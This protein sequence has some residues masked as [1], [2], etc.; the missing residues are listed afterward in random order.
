MGNISIAYIGKDKSYQENLKKALI[1]VIGSNFI[2]TIYDNNSF[3]PHL[4]FREISQSNIEVIYIDFNFNLNK[5]IKLAKYLR[6]DNKAKLLSTVSLH[7][8]LASTEEILQAEYSGIRLLHIKSGE[9]SDVVYDAL[10][11]LENY[12]FN[13]L[14]YKIAKL[15]DSAYFT[16]SL[17][18]AKINSSLFQVE[19]SSPLV[20]NEIIEIVNAPFKMFN[21][22][23]YFQ[24]TKIRDF[25]LYYDSRFSIDLVPLFAPWEIEEIY[26]EDSPVPSDLK[27]EPAGAFDIL[28]RNKKVLNRWISTQENKKHIIKKTKIIVYDSS[29]HILETTSKDLS[30]YPFSITIHTRPNSEFLQIKRKMP[31]LVVYVLNQSPDKNED[32][33]KDQLEN[34]EACEQSVDV[35]KDFE[36]QE[37]QVI[38]DMIR[39]IKTIE[40]Y[41][42]IIIIFHT[43]EK[44]SFYKEKMQYDKVISYK[45]NPNMEII[46]KFAS[47][48]D[49]TILSVKGDHIFFSSSS[50]Q[51][52][53]IKI[54]RDMIIKGIN[55]SEVYFTTPHQ[56][57]LYTL[58][59]FY[60][61]LKF[62]VTLIPNNKSSDPQLGNCYKGLIHFI[63][64]DQKKEL[65]HFVNE[66]FFREK[67]AKKKEEIE[68][69]KIQ[70]KKE[71][72][73][74][75]LQNDQDTTED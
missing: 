31:H 40:N 63:E 69:F 54:K 67:E 73:K 28:K 72:L 21:E 5:C 52:A 58:V 55:E 57:P 61:P 74:R 2:L 70:N 30:S 14:P 43:K 49:N 22:A 26:L 64:E 59:K 11:M 38:L 15:D 13:E 41:N 34:D 39:F 27:E 51:E 10:I 19:S 48:L 6:R 33:E 37:T 68:Q 62:L 56:L 16:Q 42:P 60:Y 1:K 29:L 75:E 24:V 23:T 20:E 36:D 65:R 32:Q 50:P 17:R 9:I 18:L 71:A 3:D 7:D 45:E 46:E 66:V 35:L 44:S 4:L 25:D 12:N 47:K 53:S 8:Y